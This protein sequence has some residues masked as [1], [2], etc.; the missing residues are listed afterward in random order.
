MC[1]S[2]GGRSPYYKT[3]SVTRNP[4]IAV[5]LRSTPWCMHPFC[6]SQS[7]AHP[8]PSQSIYPWSS[9]THARARTRAHTHTHTHTHTGLVP[10]TLAIDIS[11]TDSSCL[12]LNDRSH[13]MLTHYSFQLTWRSSVLVKHKMTVT[14]QVTR[15][16]SIWHIEQPAGV[17]KTASLCSSLLL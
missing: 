6:S 17:D 16:T 14:V 11:G 13:G 9:H 3:S 15:K 7:V 5:P 10:F 4:P 2:A 12:I 8:V 1:N